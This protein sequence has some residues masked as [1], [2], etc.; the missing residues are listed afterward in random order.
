[1]TASPSSR[2]RYR[3]ISA[4]C[5]VAGSVC[6]GLGAVSFV[7][8]RNLFDPVTFGRRAADSL[9]DP[10]VAAYAADLVTTGIVRGKPDL[11]AFRPMLSSTAEMVVSA[12]P[13]RAVVERAA[14]R[15]HEVAFSEGVERVL[16]SLP[17]LN[18]LVHDALSH[19]SPAVAA[20][21]PK[22]LDSTVARLADSK[23]AAIAL[24]VARV[25]KRLNWIWPVFFVLALG[26]KVLALWLA[27]D[28]Q[29]GMVRAGIGLIVTGLVVAGLVA[30]N[31]LAGV[32]VHGAKELGLVRG[33]WR[34][35][36]G[37]LTRW[38]L[39]FA[40]LG[41]LLAAGASS[42]L[43]R[44]DPLAQMTHYARTLAAPP[45]NPALRFL[46][47]VG[48]LL[49]GC[50]I[51]S[52]PA[53]TLNGAAAIIGL[54]VAYLG[55]RELFRLFLET[56]D[57]EAAALEPELRSRRGLAAALVGAMVLI[58]RRRLVL[59]AQPRCGARAPLVYWPA[60]AFP[61][62]VTGEW[63]KWFLLARTTPCQTRTRPGGCFRTMRQACLRCSRMASALC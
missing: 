51:F 16:L 23:G 58:A 17:D 59:L 26:F 21:I 5:L 42:L 9:S 41:V 8:S 48:L 49:A 22:S 1:M 24:G 25:G 47:G 57:K 56:L 11:I 50:L 28:R 2:R 10:G 52:F 30:A 40:G 37:D 35:Y 33:L 62:S 46:W 27:P 63:I 15:A 13:F 39:L 38:G 19:A 31:P 12:K 53:L 6:F 20:K 43:E 36:L 60:T 44:V 54:C 34:T 61:S 14:V 4:V 29:R 32:W 7:L 3:H 45:G 55:S 18:V